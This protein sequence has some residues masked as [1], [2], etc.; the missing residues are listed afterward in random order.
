MLEELNNKIKLIHLLVII[1]LKLKL[2]CLINNKH[3]K[4]DIKQKRKN[5]TI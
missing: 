2:E 4:I 1:Y 3:K 5:I